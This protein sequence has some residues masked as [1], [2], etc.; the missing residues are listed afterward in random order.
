MDTQKPVFLFSEGA[1]TP[2]HDLSKPDWLKQ[3]ER[4]EHQENDRVHAMSSAGADRVETHGTMNETIDVWRY[5]GTQWVIDWWDIDSH[6]MTILVNGV[7]DFA[8]IQA[9]W[10]CPMAAKLLAVDAV[11]RAHAEAH[12]QA[13]ENDTADMQAEVALH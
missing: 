11:L 7:V 3:A 6:L 9:T 4:A 1:F 10:I 8:T 2:L 5:G 12:L 13:V